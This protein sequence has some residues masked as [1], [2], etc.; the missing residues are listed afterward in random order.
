MK[1]NLNLVILVLICLSSRST[2][3]VDYS[4][5]I[6]PIFNASCAVTGCHVAGHS[7]G[8]DLT[9]CNSYALLF[10]VIS[11][12]YAPALR[13]E[14][15]SANNSVLYNKVANTGV[16]GGVMPPYTAGR[17]ISKA[18]IDL[19]KVW[20]NEG[21]HE[22]AVSVE[23]MAGELPRRFEILGNYPNPFNPTTRI[24][25]TLI[26]AGN[27]SA[28][29]HDL[30]GRLIRDLGETWT[31][32]GRHELIWDGKSSSKNFMASGI[33]IFQLRMGERSVSHKMLLLK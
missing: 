3:Q 25:F 30:S 9:E 29:V 31:E 2:G 13:V 19:I 20:I 18:N 6:Q 8:L 15:D 5:Q 7:T 23:E 10:N 27:A 12:G 32:T 16:Y 14:P 17:E 24:V 1:K 4:T 11:T 33:Y 26:E 22:Q 28:T 21:A